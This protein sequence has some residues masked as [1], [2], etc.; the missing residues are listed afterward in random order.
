MLETIRKNEKAGLNKPAFDGF[1]STRKFDQ[2]LFKKNRYKVRLDS[3]LNLL[4][5]L[6]LNRHLI[7]IN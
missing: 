2:E 3:P 6:N 5:N 1:V 4:N 7:K